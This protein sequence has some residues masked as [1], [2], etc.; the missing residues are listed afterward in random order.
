MA[1]NIFFSII[2]EVSVIYCFTDV[3]CLKPTVS[4]LPGVAWIGASVTRLDEL[5]NTSGAKPLQQIMNL[6]LLN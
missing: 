1:F 4:N 5:Q 3:S 2:S 6:D